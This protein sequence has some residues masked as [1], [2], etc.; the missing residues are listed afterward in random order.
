MGASEEGALLV[1]ITGSW[2]EVYLGPP[3]ELLLLSCGSLGVSCY[4]KM[5]GDRNY[6]NISLMPT[7]GYDE[8]GLGIV[9][10]E[11]PP[12]ALARLEDPF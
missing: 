10:S 3:D 8:D 4:L 5:L 7:L 6:A 12:E 11:I 1:A 2:W 9:L